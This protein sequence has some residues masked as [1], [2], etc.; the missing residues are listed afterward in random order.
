M[1]RL[2]AVL[3]AGALTGACNATAP[4]PEQPPEVVEPQGTLTLQGARQH[5]H[6][7]GYDHYRY[8]LRQQCFCPQQALRPVKITVRDG[9]VVA[10]TLQD[11]NGDVP[12]GIRENARTI[13]GW[14]DYLQSSE[15]RSPARLEVNYDPDTGMPARI[16]IDRDAMI[17]DDEITW[18][19]DELEPLP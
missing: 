8:V 18:H 11:G 3:C 1:S 10:L 15:E 4:S 6:A 9:K 17:S 12:D 16:H 5:W 7:N 19:L 13:P 14:L 2:L